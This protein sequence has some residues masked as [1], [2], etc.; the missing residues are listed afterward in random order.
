MEN[1][2]SRRLTGPNLIWDLPG[3]LLQVA[4]EESE[5][6]RAIDHG[7]HQLP[8]VREHRQCLEGPDDAFVCVP[9]PHD[10]GLGVAR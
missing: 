1:V 3:A 9:R 8:E 6:D 10:L 2:E 7:Q 5:R 4:V